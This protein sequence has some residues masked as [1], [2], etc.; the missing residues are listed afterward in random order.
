MSKEV[1]VHIQTLPGLRLTR[2]L[3]RTRDTGLP[4]GHA[5]ARAGCAHSRTSLWSAVV[6]SRSRTLSSI[7]RWSKLR[8]YPRRRERRILVGHGTRKQ[9]LATM[10]GNLSLRIGREKFGFDFKR[11]LRCKRILKLHLAR[12]GDRARVS[13]QG[14]ELGRAVRVCTLNMRGEP[15]IQPPNTNA[16]RIDFVFR[17]RC[18]ADSPVDTTTTRFD[19]T[20]PDAEKEEYFVAIEETIRWLGFTPS[21]IN[22]ASDSFQ[23]MYDLDEELV[24]KS[25]A[26]VCRCDD[27]ET[28]PQRGGEDVSTPRYHCEHANQYVESNLRK[29]R[30][31][32]DGGFDDAEYRLGHF[33]P[34]SRS[35]VSSSPFDI[36]TRGLFL[37]SCLSLI[38]TQLSSRM[39]M[40][41]I[42]RFHF[43]QG[44]SILHEERCH[45]DR[46]WGQGHP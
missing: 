30:G 4:Q 9:S 29:S 43:S 46:Q 28:E 32:R 45:R 22:Y 34:P 20:N 15:R 13:L 6:T 27:A 14:L 19:D 5:V 18:T 21:R 38:L 8:G 11:R 7:R 26:Y 3:S 35:S 37:A 40:S 25:Y 1:E 36:I 33:F 42:S 17:T 31:M 2:T 10:L 24:I 16:R 39:P 44:L 12:S 41:K 23:R